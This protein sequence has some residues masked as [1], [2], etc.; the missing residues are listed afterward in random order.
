MIG[1]TSIQ[2]DGI[3]YVATYQQVGRT[4]KDSD[5]GPEYARTHFRLE[6]V[7]EDPH[8]QPHDGD[9]AFLDPETPIY[10]VQGYN[11]HFRLAAR[12]NGTVVLYEAD[13]NITAQSGADLLDL[14]GKVQTIGINSQEDGTT[15]LGAISDPA[16]VAD[17]TALVL[18]APIT[19]HPTRSGTAVYF[20]VFYL[21]DGTAV[22]RAY[23]PDS[24]RTGPGHRPAAGLP[25]GGRGGPPEIGLGVWSWRLG[26]VR[27]FMV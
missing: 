23:W 22:S 10:T 2:F 6:S 13:T 16:Q 24:G 27:T 12:R 14:G 8:Y 26:L 18:A 9:A 4:I 1:W 11:P 3:Q 7:V 21:T 25:H 17:L 15:E 19:A 20:I 5:L